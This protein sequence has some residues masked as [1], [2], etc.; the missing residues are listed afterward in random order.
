V[1]VPSWYAVGY[2]GQLSLLPSV[3]W[4]ITT[5]QY[6]LVVILCGWVYRY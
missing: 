2:P 5:S 6:V 1:G 3:G 4:E